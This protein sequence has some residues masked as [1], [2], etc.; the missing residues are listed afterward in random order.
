MDETGFDFLSLTP[1]K[2]KTLKKSLKMSTKSCNPYCYS[3]CAYYSSS[4]KRNKVA[5]LVDN[6]KLFYEQMG[7]S[8][9]G[10]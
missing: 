7:D 1:E 8:A 3:N 4:Y 10:Q 6:I 2:I 9:A 5:F